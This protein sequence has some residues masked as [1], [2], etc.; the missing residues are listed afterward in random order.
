MTRLAPTLLLL[1]ACTPALSLPPP[2]SVDGRAI[3]W[4]QAY[5]PDGVLA[6]ADPSSRTVYYSEALLSLPG[7]VRAAVVLHEWCHLAGLYDEADAHRCAALRWAEYWREL[8]LVVDVLDAN[9]GV[10]WLGVGAGSRR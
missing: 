1:T 8:W 5:L 7:P 3:A 9:D 10:V 4:H 6:Q 2:S